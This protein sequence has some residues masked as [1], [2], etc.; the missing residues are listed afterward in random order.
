MNKGVFVTATGTDIGK[1]FVSALLVKALREKKINAGY[2]KPA[3]SGAVRRDGKLIPGDAEY[4]CKRAGLPGEP[5]D[6]VA[7]VF[8]QAVSPHLAARLEQRVI[9]AGGILERF[10]QVARRFD[11]VVA[12]GCG[13]LFCPLRL[14]EETLFIGEAAALLDYPLLIV[15]PAGLGGIHSAVTTFLYAKSLHLK[16]LGIVLNQYEPDSLIH[17][18]NRIQIRRLTCVPVICVEKDQDTFPETDLLTGL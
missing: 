16:V 15:S 5:G 3:L 2:F 11:Y 13:G 8:E 10:Q 9:T 14:D 18:D 17:Q 4:V 6:Y 12:E 7:Y 1:T